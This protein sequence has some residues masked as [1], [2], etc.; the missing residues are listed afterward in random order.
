MRFFL[1]EKEKTESVFWGL[2]IGT[3]S[4][5]SAIIGKR[6]SKNGPENFVLAASLQYFERY[7]VFDGRNLEDDVARKAISKSIQETKRNLFLCSQAERDLKK[8]VEREKRIN[9]VV[10][11]SADRI[12]TRI[13]SPTILRDRPEEKISKSE[14]ER[15]IGEAIRQSKN[16]AAE[17]FSAKSGV[18]A[19]EIKWLGFKAIERKI[20]GYSLPKIQGYKGRKIDFRILIVFTADYYL[21]TLSRVLDPLRIDI[22]KIASPAENLNRSC[23]ALTESGVFLDIGGD[24]TQFL[25][26]E[27]GLKAGGEIETGARAFTECLC[28]S[29]GL[30]EESSRNLKERYASRSLSVESAERIKELFRREKE[31]WYRHL[32]EAILE[33][34]GKRIPFSDFRLFGGGSILPDI[35]EVLER[36]FGE[37]RDD[38][39][40]FPDFEIKTIYPKDLSDFKNLTDNAA[41]PQFVPLLLSLSSRQG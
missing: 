35:K 37:T 33:E 1:K 40:F 20:D 5:K 28:R 24:V 7:G 10:S 38:I 31:S 6:R 30:D 25:I 17:K 12:K 36:N 41:T 14:E 21:E 3:E 22:S 8:R 11:L 23:G 4:V 39:S 9:A 27:K 34:S 13:S 29:F 32:E 19:S 15:I 16:E 2:D 18:T 26:T